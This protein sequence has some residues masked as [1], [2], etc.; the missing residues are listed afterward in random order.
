MP[1]LVQ[2]TCELALKIA[3]EYG[4]RYWPADD[5]EPLRPPPSRLCTVILILERTV[6]IPKPV[7]ISVH[8]PPWGLFFEGLP[9]FIPRIAIAKFSGIDNPRKRV[10]R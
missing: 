7:T 8:N 10:P 2:Y 3:G 6:T 4:M 5:R 1:Y 9:V